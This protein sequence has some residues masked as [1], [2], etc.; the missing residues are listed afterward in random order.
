VRECIS[1]QE[2]SRL[3]W[4]NSLTGMPVKSEISTTGQI[5]PDA[6]NQ[7]FNMINTKSDIIDKFID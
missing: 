4:Q 7:L 2:N 6:D 1:V 3:R 5:F